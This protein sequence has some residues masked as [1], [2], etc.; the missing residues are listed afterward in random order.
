ML[1]ISEHSQTEQTNADFPKPIPQHPEEIAR[2]RTSAAS[3][4]PLKE[5]ANTH[6]QVASPILIENADNTNR[7]SPLE[8]KSNKGIVDGFK[9]STLGLLLVYLAL[10]CIT[11]LLVV[12]F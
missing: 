7:H 2:E 6:P 9:Y 10:V 11:A 1:N 3:V 5:H 8:I 4:N 12:I